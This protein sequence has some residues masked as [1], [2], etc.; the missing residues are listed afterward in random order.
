MSRRNVEHRHGIG[1]EAQARLQHLEPVAVDAHTRSCD[2][3]VV[4]E[5]D[6]PAPSSRR[7]VA[8]VEVGDDVEPVLA[9]V[10]DHA[11]SSVPF[12]PSAFSSSALS[13]RTR[14]LR[15]WSISRANVGSRRKRTSSEPALSTS[16]FVSPMATASASRE[17][18][19]QGHLPEEV[20]RA[21]IAEDDL[22]AAH[23]LCDA[24]PS[25]LDDVH[26]RAVIAADDELAADRHLLRLPTPHRGAY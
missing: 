22:T 5:L 6:E 1:G 13:V 18:L 26:L 11:E 23:L 21:E 9:G 12:V 20:A 24:H 16:S 25:R 4:E 19:E 14:P 15:R 2:A 3:R 10:D 7:R 8:E 17:R